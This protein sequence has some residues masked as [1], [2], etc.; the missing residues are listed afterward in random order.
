MS[1]EDDN[2]TNNDDVN[3]LKNNKEYSEMTEVPKEEFQQ[4]ELQQEE[5]QQEELQQEELQQEEPQQ[6]E[7]QQKPPMGKVEKQLQTWALVAFVL[8]YI[9][10]V[11]Y[12]GLLG[13][14]VLSSALT[15]VT[16]IVTLVCETAAFMLM[17][18]LRVNYRKNVVG[19][20]LMWFYI[21]LVV[22]LIAITVILFCGLMRI[23]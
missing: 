9:G 16:S 5:P 1:F 13:I 8:Q 2:L 20:I 21:L 7:P 17:I 4:E 18:I 15:T 19:K 23:A 12:E 10:L 22:A 3:E 14:G 11:P 6:E